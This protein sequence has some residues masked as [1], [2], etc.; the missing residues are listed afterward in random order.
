M[1]VSSPHRSRRPDIDDRYH[2]DDEENLSRESSR[3]PHANKH[4]DCPPGTCEAV[5]KEYGGFGWTEGITLAVI[6]AISMW[7]FDKAYEKHKA[8]SERKEKEEKERE[9]R[10]EARKKDRSRARD[11][12]RD[13]ERR[14][15]QRPNRHSSVRDRDMRESRRR[16]S[17][18]RDYHRDDRDHHR[19]REA[20]R[21]ED[22]ARHKERY[23]ADYDYLR[24]QSLPPRY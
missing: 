3:K 15:S 7:N 9:E 14:G 18:P 23:P 24:R 8:K 5:E 4:E 11:R 10:E 12:D 6:G 1:S 16:D 13:W 20:R 2:Y 19:P 22:R 17:M 21:D